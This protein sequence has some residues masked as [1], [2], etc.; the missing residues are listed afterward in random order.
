MLRQDWE[1]MQR[2]N[3]VV[4]NMATNREPEY[5]GGFRSK[6]M[7][8]SSNFGARTPFA[9]PP[10]PVGFKVVELFGDIGPLIQWRLVR[11]GIAEVT[12]TQK[13]HALNAVEVYH[14]RQL[15]GQPMTV[16]FVSSASNNDVRVPQTSKYGS[17]ASVEPD[18]GIIHK[19]LFKV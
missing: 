8:Q 13:A 2:T 4:N 12:Y 19:A 10:S 3:I 15:D 18:L 6:Q 17:K 9:Q 11:P 7:A 16:V 1:Q 14:K 5:S